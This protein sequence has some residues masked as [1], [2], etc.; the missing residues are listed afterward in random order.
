MTVLIPALMDSGDSVLVTSSGSW[1]RSRMADG[2]NDALLIAV[3]LYGTQYRYDCPLVA[4]PRWWKQGKDDTSECIIRYVIAIFT[5][6][7]RC[8]KGL[9][10]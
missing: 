10:S 4:T 8:W 9:P 6:I 1:F 2:I 3:R 7:L 5:R